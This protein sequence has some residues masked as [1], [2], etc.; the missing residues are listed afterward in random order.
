MYSPYTRR[1]TAHHSLSQPG[2]K[3]PTTPIGTA[4]VS[5]VLV[6]LVIVMVCGGY[7]PAVAVTTMTAAAGALAEYVRRLATATR[8]QP[9]T[10]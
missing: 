7:P 2:T 10:A 1:L 5:V 3:S 9:P 4:A 8:E 6:V